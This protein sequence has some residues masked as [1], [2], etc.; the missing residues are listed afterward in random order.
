MENIEKKEIY[1]EYL[2]NEKEIDE[3]DRSVTCKIDITLEKHQ[4]KYFVAVIDYADNNKYSKVFSHDEMTVI[5]NILS[6]ENEKEKQELLKNLIS[7]LIKKEETEKMI[8]SLTEKTKPLYQDEIRN[9]KDKNLQLR[10]ILVGLY[11]HGELNC[12]SF[13][14]CDIKCSTQPVE[15]D[16]RLEKVKSFIRKH[17]ISNSTFLRLTRSYL[18]GAL[19]SYRGDYGNLI[20]ELER[21]IKDYYFVRNNQESF[22]E[23]DLKEQELIELLE[24]EG[25]KKGTYL[26]R[27]LNK[28]LLTDIDFIILAKTSINYKYKAGRNFEVTDLPKDLT[29][30]LESNNLYQPKKWVKSYRDSLE[31]ENGVINLEKSKSL[32][33]SIKDKIIRKN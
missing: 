6:L 18:F 26:N 31:K 21:A 20:P 33:K 29:Y 7:F 24:K 14:G 32:I 19:N 15:N 13:W 8:N 10:Y 9:L 27:F 12:D 5:Y 1:Q 28:Y 30:I 22:K 23:N 11:H 16:E 3:E 2:R 25:N 4:E 17:N